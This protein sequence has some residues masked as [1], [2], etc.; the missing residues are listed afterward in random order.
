MPQPQLHN[1][2]TGIA[3]SEVVPHLWQAYSNLSGSDPF[4]NDT[5]Y[6]LDLQFKIASKLHLPSG[7][8]KRL[9]LVA[10]LYPE[11]DYSVVSDIM[12][13]ENSLEAVC[14]DMDYIK[15]KTLPGSKERDKLK[16]ALYR[17]LG[18]AIPDARLHPEIYRLTGDHW[19]IHTRAA[20]DRHKKR[21]TKGDAFGLGMV[22]HDPYS[23]HYVDRVSSG[24]RID[25]GLMGFLKNRLRTYAGVFDKYGLDYDKMLGRFER[26]DNHPLQD[27]YRHYLNALRALWEW[28]VARFLP[29]RISVLVP[30]TSFK[31]KKLKDFTPLKREQWVKSKNPDMPDYSFRELIDLS[32][33]ELKATIM[34]IEEFFK[35]D[36]MTARESLAKHNSTPENPKIPFLQENTN[37]DT[38]LSA[39]MNGELLE[40]D[41]RHGVRSGLI[42]QIDT[43]PIEIPSLEDIANF[44]LDYLSRT[45]RTLEGL[46]SSRSPLIQLPQ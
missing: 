40:I 37:L 28:R 24:N 33:R 26:T 25:E 43:P 13:W 39:S 7:L 46:P 12:H 35:T 1:I 36:G 4:W 8:L 20:Y 27:A 17:A 45:Y 10:P 32:I 5:P 16:A 41:R 31:V 14:N 6:M 42:A 15:E 23:Y 22:G 11:H 21:E 9:P 29:Q 30:T 38:G 2:I 34:V 18:H 44:G 3:M 19:K